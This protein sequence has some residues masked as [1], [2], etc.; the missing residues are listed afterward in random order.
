MKSKLLGLLVL[1]A[2]LCLP[3][4]AFA[5]TCTPDVIPDTTNPYCL[6]NPNENQ[7]EPGDL[8]VEVNLSGT[9]LTVTA[10]GSA[11]F[12]NL[13][14]DSIAFN[15][16]NG[17][18]FVGGTFPSTWQ[19]DGTPS[20]DGFND[21]SLGT[22][23]SGA[24]CTGGCAGAGPLNFTLNG[25]PVFGSAGAIF[26]VH[27]RYVFNGNSNCSVFLSNAATPSGAPAPGTVQGCGTDI[28]EPGSLAL[29]GTGIFAAVG[30][31]RRRL[32]LP[33]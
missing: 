9:S 11:G 28:P 21:P 18:V 7:F 31:L 30:V 32:H 17:N 10:M 13:V 25:A 8:T 22:F 26:V 3:T 33:V 1:G 14:I 15:N 6:T 16:T 2:A 5:A 12:T 20:S 19:A 23:N 4:V 24:N 29:L 27:V